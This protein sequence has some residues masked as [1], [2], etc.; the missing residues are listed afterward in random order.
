MLRALVGGICAGLL[1]ASAVSG[2]AQAPV[3]PVVFALVTVTTDN[4]PGSV[5]DLVAHLDLNS[6]ITKIQYRKDA[7]VLN[8]FTTDGAKTGVTLMR[9]SGFP[10][11]SLK[12]GS[13]FNAINGGDVT[14]RILRRGGLFSGFHYREV[15]MHM[16]HL[17]RGWVLTV[18]LPSGVK[19]FNGIFMEA[20]REGDPY[21]ESRTLGTGNPKKDAVGIK[22]LVFSLDGVVADT[23]NT[24]ELK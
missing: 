22:N 9:E 4:V 15:K 14:F 1:W 3:Q 23:V 11:V 21:P 13:N 5:Y 18:N 10:V 24:V 12:T 16:A 20:Y 2:A 19:E 6:T 17:T 8:E 7:V